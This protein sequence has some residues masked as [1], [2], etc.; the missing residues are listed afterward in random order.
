MED[1]NTNDYES[2]FTEERDI[3][4]VFEIRDSTETSLNKILNDEI[5]MTWEQ[6]LYEIEKYTGFDCD[7]LDSRKSKGMTFTNE[8]YYNY[9]GGGEYDIG[10]AIIKIWQRICS[11]PNKEEILAQ[12]R[13]DIIEINGGYD[14]CI[15]GILTQLM[16]C[17]SGYDPDIQIKYSSNQKL[18]N[19]ASYYS[20][21]IENEIIDY[22]T[23]FDKFIEQIHDCDDLDENV[24]NDW[25]VSFEERFDQSNQ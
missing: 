10:T 25:I 16:N 19:L 21:Q 22:E 23:A 8:H 9:G 24:K 1:F 3:I 6:V 13:N 5:Y 7:E 4:E 17:L 11:Q 18:S 14:M 15:R 2:F 12:L 20:N